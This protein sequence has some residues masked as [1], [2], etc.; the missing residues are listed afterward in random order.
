MPELR[1][2][3]AAEA[4]RA[5]RASLSS[6]P[7]TL[8]VVWYATKTSPEGDSHV[9]RN[10]G[11][12]AD[13]LRAVVS[14]TAP[15]GRVAFMG[16]G[17]V[18]G[19]RTRQHEDLAG[20]S[21][22]EFDHDATAGAVTLGT[23]AEAFRALGLA[24]V[25][26]PSPSDPTP[27]PLDA[28]R[29]HAHAPLA[30]GTTPDGLKLYGLAAWRALGAL[31]GTTGLDR[32]VTHAGALAFVPPR[33]APRGPEAVVCV[34]GAALDL[35]ALATAGE[36]AGWF[37]WRAARRDAKRA[38]MFPPSIASR[39]VDALERLG[40]IRGPARASGK[41]ALRC[42]RGHEH[43]TPAD[44]RGDTSTVVDVNTGYPHC[45]HTHGGKPLTGWAMVRALVEAHP[46]LA[47][48]AAR[49]ETIALVE[50]VREVL[51]LAPPGE[52]ARRVVHPPGVAEDVA[53]A[54]DEAMRRPRMV[55]YTPTVGAGK[56]RGAA[57][58]AARDAAKM[59]RLERGERYASTAVGVLVDQRERLRELTG[60]VLREL[61]ARGVE[62]AHVRVNTP[63]H[64]VNDADGGAVCI[65]RETAARLYQLGASARGSLCDRANPGGGRCEN[66]KTCGARDP[67]V[68]WQLRGGVAV[69]TPGDVPKGPWVALATHANAVPMAAALR[70]GALLIVD[71]GNEAFQPRAVTI[72]RDALALGRAWANVLRGASRPEGGRP[73]PTPRTVA[74]ALMDA[75]CSA[76][77][78]GLLALTTPEARDDFAVRAVAD[79]LDAS[80]A[81][82]A[83][84][85][86]YTELPGADPEVVARATL[87]RWAEGAGAW[88]VRWGGGVG[89]PPPDGGAVLEGLARWAVDPG[90]RTAPMD[91]PADGSPVTEALLTWPSPAGRAAF[92]VVARDG[93]VL[94]LDATG[95]L[96]L[97]RAAVPRVD[98]VHDP[99]RV[100]DPTSSE[101]VRVMVATKNG[102]RRT[103]TPGTRTTRT[104]RWGP[105]SEL[106]SAL[107]AALRRGGAT[108][109]GAVFA[110]LPLRA[111]CEVLAL[112]P[113]ADESRANE[114]LPTL[115]LGK[116]SAEARASIAAAVGA[117]PPEAREAVR[118]LAALGVTWA[119]YGGA[120]SR[121]SNALSG[122]GWL[123]TL[124]DPRPALAAS[125]LLGVATG[126]GGRAQGDRTAAEVLTQCHGR[127]RVVQRPGERIVLVH[128][129]VV[130][131]LDWCGPG[132]PAVD[133]V[134]V[135]EVLAWR[136]SAGA[137]TREPVA[138]L[139]LSQLG[140]RQVHPNAHPDVHAAVAAGWGVREI[141]AAVGV[142]P[143]R[144]S[145]WITLGRKPQ[146]GAVLARLRQLGDLDG[147]ATLRARL[148]GMERGRGVHG[149]VN[150]LSKLCRAEGVAAPRARALGDFMHL[151]RALPREVLTG[152]VRVM[153]AAERVIPGAS[154]RTERLQDSGSEANRYASVERPIEP[155]W[156]FAQSVSIG[157]QPP[158]ITEEPR[159]GTPP[160]AEPAAPPQRPARPPLVRALPPAPL[161]PPTQATGRAPKPPG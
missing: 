160:A 25:F 17:L 28:V 35:G 4:S 137:A 142:G 132:A 44:A 49:A 161:A 156:P 97:H 54:A 72:D 112:D 3:S 139:E 42:P 105:A 68:P 61:A 51:A 158:G 47:P 145:E 27:N 9:Y 95:D 133:V 30:D 73:N 52:T 85:R 125:R 91:E 103:L 37:E 104:V 19:A 123:V 38:R 13:D 10:L 66:Y 111:A 5:L 99:V 151:K 26:Y 56:S 130:P 155:L 94:S 36:L 78:A 60:D 117:A 110:G 6:L 87:G 116:L 21:L 48:Y 45:S 79:T 81:A 98:V 141:A 124:G 18:E 106:L 121:G 140:E 57:A 138:D 7:R 12:L 119:H 74:L 144:V 16:A 120:L 127:A 64:E 20:A 118:Q 32:N 88:R 102:G 153:W 83:D 82:L 159:A 63:P 84:A 107:P 58:R 93:S 150:E 8:P 15:K 148:L 154:E 122:V 90:A 77:V 109:P 29:W 152:L 2:C 89:L 11:E 92:A 31:L 55:L 96:A 115:A 149:I 65:Y 100:P 23:A 69:P 46:E 22:I 1:A 34:E 75:A 50:E 71:E 80:P 62:G 146:S 67:W 41:A 14:R 128:V 134:S 53:A 39:W 108:G 114:V 59:P 101:V 129:G 33:Y 86:E 40:L 43:S 113:S 76:G 143:I 136:S 157:P 24:G 70:V 147:E 131:P 126:R 135:A